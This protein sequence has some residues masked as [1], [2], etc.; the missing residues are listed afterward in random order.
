[1]G[2]VIL[3]AFSN[4]NDSLILCSLLLFTPSLEVFKARLDGPWA[5]WAGM[6]CGGWCP[7]L[8]EGV[9]AS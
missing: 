9:G 2:L 5:V 8:L 1:L 7:C 3:E 6:N 4:L